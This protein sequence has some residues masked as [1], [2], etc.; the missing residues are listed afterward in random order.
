MEF[1]CKV[2][3]TEMRKFTLS[4]RDIVVQAIYM[5]H[6]LPDGNV[7]HCCNTFDVSIYVVGGCLAELHKGGYIVSSE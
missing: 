3:N 6:S 2:V 5:E 7:C 4:Y 1:E